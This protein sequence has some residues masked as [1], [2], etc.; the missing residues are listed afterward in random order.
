VSGFLN[1]LVNTRETRVFSATKII[2]ALALQAYMLGEMIRGSNGE[3]AKA[4]SSG[5]EFRETVKL[6]PFSNTRT[7][8]PGD[9]RTPTRGT[10]DTPIIAPWRFHE[11]NRP[12]NDYEIDTNEGDMYAQ[13]KDLKTSI[14]QGLY[15]DHINFMEAQL[16]AV[17]D[18]PNMENRNPSPTNKMY[19]LPVTITESG[20]QPPTSVW[21]AAAATVTIQAASPFTLTNW[22]NPVATYDS[23]Q[24][25]DPQTGLFSAFDELMARLN[26][27]PPPGYEKYMENDDLRA[28]KICTNLDGLNAF[29]ALLR[30][31]NNS[32][33][34]GP[35]DPAYGM[36]VFKG[37]P[38][39]W[40]PQLDLSLLDE[41]G[42]VS[43]P[44]ASVAEGTYTG[45]AYPAGKPR[46][47]FVNARYLKSIFHPQHMMRETDPITGGARQR[48]VNTVFLESVM[49]PMNFDR[50][51]SGLIR[52]A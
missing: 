31:S 23:T 48:D 24:L 42:A 10:E 29:Q 39:K 20:R 40:I 1:Y 11:T 9:E 30:D 2:N 44:L 32:T 13:F 49:N 50:R 43:S 12:I 37:I 18:G 4:K 22:R 8:L 3:M 25:D 6:V 14:M 51:R 26:F 28:L 5:R 52:P 7:F 16:W 41:T 45:Q 21:G 17:P 27:T 15:T 33:R 35:Q 19:S 46:F 38:V 36:P 47:F 34:A